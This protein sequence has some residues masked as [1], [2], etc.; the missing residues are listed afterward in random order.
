MFKKRFLFKK[1]FFGLTCEI[2]TLIENL[3]KA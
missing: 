3:N 1:M 2:K